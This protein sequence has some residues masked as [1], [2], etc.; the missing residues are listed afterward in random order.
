V[1]G[2]VSRHIGVVIASSVDAVHAFARDP[3]NLPRWA[4]GLATGEAERAEDALVVDSPMGRVVVVFAPY[5]GYGVLDHDV[6]LPSGEVV[7]NPVRV[8]AHPDGAEVVFTLRQGNASDEDFARD[9]RLVAEDLD[10]LRSLV[11][12]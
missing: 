2:V 12:H 9:A 3:A 6:T 5:N 8:L 7:H 4:A 11:E 10:R 1:L